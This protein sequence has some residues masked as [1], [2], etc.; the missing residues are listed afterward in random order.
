VETVGTISMAETAGKLASPLHA[1]LAGSWRGVRTIVCAALLFAG[2]ATYRREV[3]H[4]LMSFGSII[5]GEE[6]KSG[7]TAPVEVRPAANNP[8]A[9]AKPIMLP[10]EPDT[11][12]IGAEDAPATSVPLPPLT[13]D[14]ARGASATPPRKQG[15]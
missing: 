4:L 13:A 10:V 14:P 8:G 1:S 12:K 15:L 7:A 11:R 2:L 3:G 9:E 6:Q 5:A